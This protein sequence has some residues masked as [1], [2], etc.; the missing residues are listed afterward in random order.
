MV[1]GSGMNTPS[2]YEPP[3]APLDVPEKKEPPSLG[4]LI[5]VI[6]QLALGGIFIIVGAVEGR[7]SLFGL[8]LVFLGIRSFIKYQA[9]VRA[10]RGSLAG[11]ARRDL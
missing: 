6:V 11:A 4:Y 7:L 1:A 8:I 3:R 9:R 2:P 5:G 10:A